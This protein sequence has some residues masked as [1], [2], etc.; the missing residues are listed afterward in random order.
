VIRLLA[1][2]SR[3]NFVMADD[4]KGTVTLKLEDVPW[5]QALN[6]I[7]EMNSLGGVREGN[8]IRVTT[9]ANLAKQRAQE[10][11]AKESK[12]KAEDLLTRVVYINYAKAAEMKTL[13][14]KL[15]SS[16]GEI[17]VDTRTNEHGDR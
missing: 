1:E 11:Q 12:I 3:L 6:I 13:L 9:L 17:M 16:R 2:V 4:V 10:A 15:L 8:I 5:D 7:L 14:D